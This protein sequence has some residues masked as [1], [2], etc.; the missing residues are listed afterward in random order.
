MKLKQRAEATSKRRIMHFTVGQPFFIGPLFS[1]NPE[2]Q[3]HGLAILKS[4]A[5]L[6][7]AMYQPDFYAYK[8]E[9]LERRRTESERADLC[10]RVNTMGDEESS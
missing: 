4:C 6:F 8:G 1:T 2:G 7:R 3:L 10:R 5:V 9:N